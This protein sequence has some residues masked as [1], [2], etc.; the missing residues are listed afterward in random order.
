MIAIGNIFYDSEKYVQN[1]KKWEMQPIINHAWFT[2]YKICRFGLKVYFSF[3]CYS[4]HQYVRKYSTSSQYVSYKIPIN[5]NKHKWKVNSPSLYDHLSNLP[6]S[7]NL[8]IYQGLKL[9]SPHQGP[10]L[11]LMGPAAAFFGPALRRQVFGRSIKLSL[12]LITVAATF[13]GKN[14]V[15]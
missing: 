3:K 1:T 14:G 13:P 9:L 7:L 5:N 12:Q 2:I 4:S 8:N 6:S 10:V 15:G 11:D